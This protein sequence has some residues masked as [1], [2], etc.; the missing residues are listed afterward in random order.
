MFRTLVYSGDG[1]VAE[2]IDIL[3]TVDG[4]FRLRGTITAAGPVSG[5]IL[6]TLLGVDVLVIDDTAVS[7]RGPDEGVMAYDLAAGMVADVQGIYDEP[8][9]IAT[10]L[11]VGNRESEGIVVEFEGIISAMEGSI[12]QVDTEGG[13]PAAVVVT[14]ETRVRGTLEVGKFIEVKGTLNEALA[15]VAAEIKVDYD[16]DRDADNDHR[17]VDEERSKTRREI[18]LRGESSLEGEAEIRFFREGDGFLQRFEVEFHN[19]EPNATYGVR[20]FIGDDAL[21]F[22]TVRANVGGRVKV[23]FRTDGEGEERNI[24]LLLPEDRTVQDITRVEIID[25]EGNVVLTG[26]F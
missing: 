5:G 10:R 22:G 18:R 2:E 7:R 9:L 12:L 26:M 16:G 4:Q 15:V 14:D 13:G 8:Q 6:I 11:K 25:A 3:D 17:E 23:R 1:P 19:A 24:G 21:D 20:V